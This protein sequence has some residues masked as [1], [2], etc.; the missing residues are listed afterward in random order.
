MGER[1]EIGKR[2][3]SRNGRWWLQGNGTDGA[4]RK[5]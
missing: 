2:E 5:G 1:R 4:I 3:S